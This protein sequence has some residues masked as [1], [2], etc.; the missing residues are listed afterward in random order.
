MTK[1][2]AMEN[3]KF[4]PTAAAG[5]APTLSH[6]FAAGCGTKKNISLFA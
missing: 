4:L 2:L 5:W 6:C 3:W 1:S